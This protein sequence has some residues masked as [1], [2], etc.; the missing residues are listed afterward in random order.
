MGRTEILELL[1]NAHA[2]FD[3]T[4]FDRWNGG[5]ST[6]TLRLE[7]PIAI[8][9]AVQ[10]RL[11]VIE[12]E[13]GEKLA[14]VEQLHPNDLVGDVTITP[15]APEPGDFMTTARNTAIDFGGRHWANQSHGPRGPRAQKQTDSTKDGR[16]PATLQIFAGF[17][18]GKETPPSK[19]VFTGTDRDVGIN[20]ARPQRCKF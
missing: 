16:L 20:A 14:Y 8:Y 5:T 17:P 19:A 12:K 3:E 18:M 10:S 4:N 9:A 7:D 1:E 2:R 11:A 13:I 15:L 6:W